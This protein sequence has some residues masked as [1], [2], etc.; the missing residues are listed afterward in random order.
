[1]KTAVRT[2]VIVLLVAGAIVAKDRLGLRRAASPAATQ[3]S[4]S[5]REPLPGSQFA[6][7]LKSGK[8]TMADFGAGWC[9]ACKK[10]VP[11]L[12]ES[13]ATYQG[14]ANVVFVDTDTYPEQAK[15]FQITAIPTQIYFDTK[16]KEAARHVGFMPMEDVSAQMA[17]LGVK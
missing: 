4:G 6:P 15:S 1:M 9:E 13:A 3:A 10:M 2:A 12:A 14:K 11:V 5:S 8:P 17:A 16:G 7:S